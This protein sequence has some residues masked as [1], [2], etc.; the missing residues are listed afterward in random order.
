MARPQA[1]PLALNDGTYHATMAAMRWVPYAPSDDLITDTDDGAGKLGRPRG[2]MTDDGGDVEI[3]DVDGTSIVVSTTA[4]VING[5]FSPTKV[6]AGGTTAATV[7]LI[8]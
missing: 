4:F 8:Y 1:Q 7:Y 5:D 2:I 3:E 6:T